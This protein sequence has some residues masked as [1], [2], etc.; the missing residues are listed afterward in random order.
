MA[1]RK[2]HLVSDVTGYFKGSWQELKQVQWPT[3]R[4][5]WAMTLAVIL[6]S[7]FL[8]AVIVLLDIIF[9]QLFNLAIK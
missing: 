4:A 2:K 9:Q 5:T 7:A 3:R 8:M 6:Y 1:K